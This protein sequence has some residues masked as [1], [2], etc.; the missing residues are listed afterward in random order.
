MAQKQGSVTKKQRRMVRDWNPKLLALSRSVQTENLNDDLRQ[1]YALDIAQI[2][3]GFY[4]LLAFRGEQEAVLLVQAILQDILSSC[5]DRHHWRNKEGRED[6][7]TR[8]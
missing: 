7:E 5:G 8:H 4:G 1:L 3:S 2:E 6:A